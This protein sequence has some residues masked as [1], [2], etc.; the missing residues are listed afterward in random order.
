MVETH[1]YSLCAP[2]IVLDR[3]FKGKGEV[4]DV[5]AVEVVPFVDYPKCSHE[6]VVDDG[7]LVLE[8]V[9]EVVLW[10]HC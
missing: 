4:K 7:T 1:L 5:E 6:V 9:Q 3:A 10:E 2:V 8:M